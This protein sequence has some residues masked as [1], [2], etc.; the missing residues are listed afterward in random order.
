MAAK[1]L[2]TTYYEGFP[3]GAVSLSLLSD[4]GQ[5][6]LSFI[7]TCYYRTT[8]YSTYH[9]TQ[10]IHRHGKALRAALE[11][12]FVSLRTKQRPNSYHFSPSANYS[13][14]LWLTDS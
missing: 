12:I 2:Q 7:F 13:I 4:Q 11:T 9:H 14:C 8:T 10:N 6:S 5:G 1:L 3:V